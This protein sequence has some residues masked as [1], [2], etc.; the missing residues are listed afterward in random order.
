VGRPARPGVPGSR[1]YTGFDGIAPG[2]T[3]GLAQWVL[4]ARRTSGGM[5]ANLGTYGV[6]NMRGKKTTSVHATG[7]AWDAGYRPRKGRPASRTAA[8]EWLERIIAANAEGGLAA[9][10]DYAYGTHGRG[11]FC[12]RQAWLNYKTNTILG[13]GN[14]ASAWFHIEISPEFARRPAL[15]RQG[16]DRIFPEI[17]RTGAYSS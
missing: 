5:L 13:G 2:V 11:W 14:P 3:G 9:V 16:F 17:P 8:L 12:D 15:I 4:E 10:L 6:R 1:P 7:R